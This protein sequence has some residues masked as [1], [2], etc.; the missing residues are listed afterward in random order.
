VV[1]RTVLSI[2]VASVHPALAVYGFAASVL[3]GVLTL[4]YLRYLLGR[5]HPEAV[6]E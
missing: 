3:I 1:A 4:P 5:I 2:S 6:M